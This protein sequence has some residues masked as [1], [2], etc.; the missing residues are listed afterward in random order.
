MGGVS[1]PRGTMN[2]R[3]I[4]NGIAVLLGTEGLIAPLPSW[5]FVIL[6]NV[7]RSITI[8]MNSY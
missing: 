3:Q 4:L 1:G 6:Y 2:L 7:L 5:S 8:R